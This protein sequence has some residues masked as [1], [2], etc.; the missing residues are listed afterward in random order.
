MMAFLP[1]AFTWYLV[2]RGVCGALATAMMGETAPVRTN[3]V[4]RVFPAGVR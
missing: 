2:A 1:L 4:P 3:F